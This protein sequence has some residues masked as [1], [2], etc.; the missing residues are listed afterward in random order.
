MK[1]VF[2]KIGSGFVNFVQSAQNLSNLKYGEKKKPGWINK[3]D[4]NTP[5]HEKRKSLRKKRK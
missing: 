2:E 5:N 3:G 4:S 1:N